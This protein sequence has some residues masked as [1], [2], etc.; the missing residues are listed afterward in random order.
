MHEYELRQRVRFGHHRLEKS[1]C[2]CV[3]KMLNSS[4]QK[5]DIGQALV[6][7]SLGI[8]ALIRSSMLNYS[9]RGVYFSSQ[10]VTGPSL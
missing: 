4:F 7:L 8:S 2:H 3:V 6:V 5:K 1:H 9:K 10:M